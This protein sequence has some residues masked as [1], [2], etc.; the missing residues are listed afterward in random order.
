MT[1]SDFASGLDRRGF[2]Q[3][4]G[5]AAALAA[6]AGRPLSAA[7]P[8]VPERAVLEIVDT[9]QHLWDLAKLRL[10]WLGGVK[11]LDRSFLMS[12]YLAA[13]QGE[14]VVQTVYMEVDVAPEQLLAEAR[15]VL[16]LCDRPDNPLVA[17]VLGGRP[18]DPTFGDYLASF[19][20]EPRVKGIRQVLHSG[21]TPPSYFLAE[22]FVAGLRALGARGLS[23]DLCVKADDLA[24]V[25]TLIARCPDTAFILDH[26]GNPDLKAASLDPWRRGIDAVA[27][28]PNVVCKVSG[29]VGGL[30]GRPWQ[31][32]DL[33]PVVDHAWTAFGPDRLVFGG[34]W[35]VC[36]LAASFAQ[37]CAALRTIVAD[38]P[39]AE[40]RKLFSENARRV[41][42]LT[43][44][45][46]S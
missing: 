15:Y 6:G 39:L 7:E 29:F 20:D 23:F 32:E 45:P 41:Y 1:L 28:R 4:V 38:R 5:G 26:C 22:A 3:S 19:A 16:A 34:D 44:K 17:A 46:R 42:R 36:T 13:A 10:P 11:E 37:W 2:L 21:Q 33:A 27:A 25:A 40:Q 9:H 24:D 43:A 31:P 30:A 8:E 14:H 18:A 35:P 12:D